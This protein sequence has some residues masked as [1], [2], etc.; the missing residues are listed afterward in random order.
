MSNNP[1]MIKEFCDKMRSVGIFKDIKDNQDAL[2]K[3]A[4]IMGKKVVQQ[5]AKIIIEGDAGEDAFIL[6]K[7]SIRIIKNTLQNEE[8]TVVRLSDA[9]NAIIGELALLDSD[10]RSATVIA[11]TPC[12]LMIIHRKDFIDFG[13]KY[14]ELALPITRN[15]AIILS[16]RLRKASQD[17]ITLFSALVNEID[18]GQR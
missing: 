1:T 13:N 10:K 12:E 18:V 5:G 15:I 9:A 17:I 11:E 6:L 2:E 14:P 4:S 16:G 3:F 8:Y 7:G